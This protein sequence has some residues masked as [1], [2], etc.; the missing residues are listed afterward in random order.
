MIS[1]EAKNFFDQV[2]LTAAMRIKFETNPEEVAEEVSELAGYIEQEV[3]NE[4]NANKIGANL[5]A[6][7]NSKF[8]T[9]MSN[10]ELRKFQSDSGISWGETIEGL[11]EPIISFSEFLD[12]QDEQRVAYLTKL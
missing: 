2:E 3:K 12:L 4:E 11:E 10:A 5:D 8:K 1:D 7:E 9:G 6:L